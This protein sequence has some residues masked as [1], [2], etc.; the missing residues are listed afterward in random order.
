MVVRLG[1][2][3]IL[4]RLLRELQPDWSH[5]FFRRS[6]VPVL[7]ARAGS[8]RQMEQVLLDAQ[9]GQRNDSTGTS[10]K[11]IMSTVPAKCSCNLGRNSGSCLTPPLP[12]SHVRRTTSAWL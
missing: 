3:Y 2:M 7:P 1:E 11:C 6:R 5:I 9:A 12:L 4:R 8:V 10:T